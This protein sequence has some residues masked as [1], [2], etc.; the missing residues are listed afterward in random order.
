MILD[1]GGT[2]D[3][4]KYFGRMACHVFAFLPLVNYSL[5][6]FFMAELSPAANCPYDAWSIINHLNIMVKTVKAGEHFTKHTRRRTLKSG[7]LII[8]CKRGFWSCEGP[9]HDEVQRQAMHY[10][11]QYYM[12]GDY[13]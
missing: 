1:I 12:D 4:A 5:L 6:R 13:D 9:D 10:F 3:V 11:L 8:R 2:L 7:N